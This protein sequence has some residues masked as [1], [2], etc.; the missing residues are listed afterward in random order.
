M[1]MRHERTTGPAGVSDH[2]SRV[3][4][5]TRHDRGTAVTQVG[6]CGAGSVGVPKHDPVPR[7]QARPPVD[8][9]DLVYDPERTNQHCEPS[10]DQEQQQ[11]R[12]CM[13]TTEPALHASPNSQEPAAPAR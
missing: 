5:L 12:Q 7:A 11:N 1:K 9:D 3:D 10:D 6:V 8:V 13:A 2:L 4:A